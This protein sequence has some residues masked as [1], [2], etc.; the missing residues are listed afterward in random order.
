MPAPARAFRQ[1]THF[2]LTSNMRFFFPAI[3]ALLATAQ[4]A[5]AYCCFSG[6]VGGCR[7]ALEE[8]SLRLRSDELVSRAACCCTAPTV[9]DCNSRCVSRRRDLAQTTTHNNPFT[10]RISKP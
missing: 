2:T 5:T 7:R 6:G 8:P 4:T 3:I 10:L 1:P 9:N